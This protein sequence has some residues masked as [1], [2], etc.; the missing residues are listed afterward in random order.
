M[1]LKAAD[2]PIVTISGLGTAAGPAASALP[3]RHVSGQ[4]V[5]KSQAT[6]S[7]ST[8]TLQLLVESDWD[9]GTVSA[10]SF[11][12]VNPAS[13]QSAATLSIGVSWGGTYSIAPAVLE[14]D[15]VNATTETG[16]AAGD[17]APL[18]V[19]DPTFIVR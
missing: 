19:Y 4:Q 9:R 17:A 15:T 13:Q 18:K 2:Y 10:F 8:G 14:S 1:S 7:K 3:I 16:T 5:L 11:A 12:V 6:W